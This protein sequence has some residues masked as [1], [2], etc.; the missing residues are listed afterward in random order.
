M[1]QKSKTRDITAEIISFCEDLELEGHSNLEISYAL[2]AAAIKLMRDESSDDA[3]AFY[4]T[5]QQ[6]AGQIAEACSPAH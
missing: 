2:G 1:A 3:A 5:L 4:R 6:C